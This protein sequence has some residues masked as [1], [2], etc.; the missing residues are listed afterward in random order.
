MYK[1][2]LN[3]LIE[4]SQT[5]PICVSV[6]LPLEQTLPQRNGNALKVKEAIS[7]VK[8]QLISTYSKKDTAP[9]MQ[10]LDAVSETIELKKPSKGMGIFISSGFNKLVNFPFTVSEKFVIDRSFEIRDLVYASQFQIPYWVVL[11]NTKKIRIFRGEAESLLEVNDENFPLAYEEQYQFVVHQEPYHVEESKIKKERHR[12]FLRHFNKLASPYFKTDTFPVILLG[13]QELQGLFDPIFDHKQRIVLRIAGNFSALTIN[14]LAAKVWDA[15]SGYLRTAGD[16]IV[17]DIRESMGK[18]GYLY[19][20]EA[21]WRVAQEGR[22]DLLVVEK[23]FK[24]P[25]YQDP[26]SGKPLFHI[27]NTSGLEQTG[28]A[29]DDIIEMVLGKK[30]EVVFLENGKLDDYDHIAVRTRY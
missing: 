24:F 21:A 4:R 12:Q 22:A 13:V 17:E 14:Q 1:S 6:I 23:D 8:Q 11:L 26:R 18:R 3:E 16:R 2:D 29:V 5:K 19:G 20:I 15:M 7:Q 27:S 25:A 30:G 28:D 10:E 9:L